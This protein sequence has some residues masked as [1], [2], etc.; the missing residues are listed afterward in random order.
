[1]G[2]LSYW[3]VVVCIG[4]VGIYFVG[5]VEFGY[6]VKFDLELW[7]IMLFYN[8]RFGKYVFVFVSDDWMIIGLN[9]LS[10]LSIELVRVVW[11][12]WV[13]GL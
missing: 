9:F 8:L 7:Y 3:F 1:M 13:M 10:G 5:Y 6:I 2:K 4:V 12:I 11:W